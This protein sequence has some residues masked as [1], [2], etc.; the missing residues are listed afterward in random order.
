MAL[1]IC[2]ENF[3]VGCFDV[4]CIAQYIQ[5]GFEVRM[6]ASEFYS[7]LRNHFEERDGYWFKQE[8]IKEYER[9][10]RT[11]RFIFF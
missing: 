7:M 10:Y 9:T 8:Q 2:K 6:D 3:N 5:N 11:A 1:S 4:G